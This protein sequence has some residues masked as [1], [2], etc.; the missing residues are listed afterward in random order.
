ML[1]YPNSGIREI[2]APL[3][4]KGVTQDRRHPRRATRL[5]WLFSTF[6]AGA[7]GI[8]ILLLRMLVGADAILLGWQYLV[9]HGALSIP[10]LAA[11]LILLAG[12]SLVVGFLTPVGAA[13]VVLT[14]FSSELAWFRALVGDLLHATL[15]IKYPAAVS[16]AIG[17]LG[18]GWFSLDRLIFGR[19]EVI[20]PRLSD[21]ARER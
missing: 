16:A 18:P 10:S 12:I 20:I 11:G 17:L 5:R 1:M 8:G 13:M 15:P 19:R 2:T 9:D 3:N 7:P 6:P 4:L 21:P 14:A